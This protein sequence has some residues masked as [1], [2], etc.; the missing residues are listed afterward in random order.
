VC[1]SHRLVRNPAHLSRLGPNG[2]LNLD[3]GR[4]LQLRSQYTTLAVHFVCLPQLAPGFG[5]IRTR[6]VVDA[7]V[8]V[9]LF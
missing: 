6:L 1:D 9:G 2:E 4:I 5:H 7:G 8:G 3:S